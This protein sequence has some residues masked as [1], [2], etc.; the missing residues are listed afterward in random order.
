M[1]EYIYEM[2][3]APFRLPG[4]SSLF[5]RYEDIC[6]A[7]EKQAQRV[8]QF[9]SVDFEPRMLNISRGVDHSIE[10]ND[11]KWKPN[12]AIK[13]NEKWKTALSGQQLK[14]FESIAGDINRKFGYVD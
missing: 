10:G 6:N 3:E 9:L 1:E 8:A 12:N 2:G 11:M 7:P 5:I 13:L 4:E 14:T